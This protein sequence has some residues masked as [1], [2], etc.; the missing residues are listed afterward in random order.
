[1]LRLPASKVR[2]SNVVFRPVSHLALGTDFNWPNEIIVS[3]VLEIIP[4]KRPLNLLIFKHLQEWPV[5]LLKWSDKDVEGRARTLEVV[6]E[7]RSYVK[8]IW[9]P[10]LSDFCTSLTGITQVR[11]PP[12]FHLYHCLTD[13]SPIQANI[14]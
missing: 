12:I 7:F 13:F 11:I 6:D 2:D 8:P 10:H 4:E 5:V 14:G 9:R 3:R 1:M